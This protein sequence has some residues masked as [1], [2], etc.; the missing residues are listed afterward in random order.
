M[1][2]QR[3]EASDWYAV[4]VMLYESL[5]GE[6]PFSGRDPMEL[7]KQKQTEDPP[8]LALR[9]NMPADLAQLTDG[10]LKPRATRATERGRHYG[11]ASAGY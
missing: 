7:L 10:L 4:G 1:F 8:L 6:T 3:S 11:T 9:D 2:G 5:T